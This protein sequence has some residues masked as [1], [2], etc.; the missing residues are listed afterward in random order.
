M[1]DVPYFCDLLQALAVSRGVSGITP[2][3][4]GRELQKRIG[5]PE[6]LC[7]VLIDGLGTMIL[8]RLPRG[9]FL[10]S[11]HEG[12]LRSV[13]PS[14]TA[15][16]MTSLSTGLP[17][18]VHGIPGRYMYLKERDLHIDTLA[19]RTRT[20]RNILSPETK[21]LEI[22]PFPSLLPRMAGEVFSLIP[23]VLRNTP[24]EKVLAGTTPTVGYR[25][26]SSIPEILERRI[27]SFTS[28][29]YLYTYIWELDSLCHRVGP[30]DPEVDKLLKV[31]DEMLEKLSEKVLP[32][33]TLV[34]SADHGQFTV[35][36]RQEYRFSDDH[37]VYKSLLTP[38]FGEPRALQFLIKRGCHERFVD[39][40]NASFGKAFHL[41]PMEEVE[42]LGLFGGTT[43]SDYAKQ[44]FGDYLAVARDRGL[45]FFE[46]SLFKAAS[47]RGEHG[48]L[49]PEERIIPFLIRGK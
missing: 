9:S 8:D 2:T 12:N 22:W 49:L 17:P 18:A 15:C 6:I 30:D 11:L 36:P 7:F 46:N 34:I 1:T 45:L 38:P 41:Y 43:F 16:A 48:G 27:R 42:K 29:G 31:L 24:F 47:H 14:T 4:R 28:R 39:D 40:F 3:V 10:R 20:E 23:E 13:F 26:L 37:P 21:P 44:R 35:D 5:K 25:D 19:F 32:R 33:G